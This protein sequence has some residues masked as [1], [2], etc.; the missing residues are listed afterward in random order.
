[1]RAGSRSSTFPAN[2]RRSDKVEL[3][4][5]PKTAGRAEAVSASQCRL[6]LL[7]AMPHIGGQRTENS[8]SGND[9]QRLI[10]GVWSTVGDRDSRNHQQ[11]SWSSGRGS[12][13]LPRMMS[14]VARLAKRLN[15]A[16]RNWSTV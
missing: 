10:A 6:H 4:A 9:S 11:T 15:R 16:L 8:H 14:S 1:G 13:G 5:A 7:T 12:I 3:V 2:I